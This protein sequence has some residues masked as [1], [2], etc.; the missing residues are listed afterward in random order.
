MHILFLGIPGS[1]KTTQVDR[2]ASELGLNTIKMGNILRAVA[3][4]PSEMGKHVKEVMQS[5]ALVEDE[6]VAEMI[7]REASKPENEKGFIMEG[8]PRTV[9]Q[10]EMFNPGF[11]KVFY[12]ELPI[13][14]AKQR[15]MVRGRADDVP[16]AIEK[17]LKVQL[18]DLEKLLDFYKDNLVRIEGTL[19]MDTVYKQIKENL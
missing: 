14:V 19:D 17:R 15:L 4:E 16:E 5:G 12:L 7:K 13:E 11:E 8:Y 2:L 10:V 18:E 3:Q 6:T 1:G 9:E